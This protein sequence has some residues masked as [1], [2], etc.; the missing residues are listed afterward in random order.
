MYFHL[1]PIASVFKLLAARPAFKFRNRYADVILSDYG[2]LKV[3]E[4]TF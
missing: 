4:G 3:D 1:S 2:V